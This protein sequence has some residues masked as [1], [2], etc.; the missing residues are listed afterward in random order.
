M[1]TKI[2][3]FTTTLNRAYCL[4]ELYRSLCRQT[5]KDFEWLIIN[6]GSDDN[7]DELIKGWILEK[8]LK[9][10]VYVKNETNGGIASAMNQAFDI[11]K[12]ELFFKVDSDDYLKDNAIELIL[13]Y[14]ATIEN[15][16]YFAGVAGYRCYNNNQVIG[17]GW[18]HA[19][20]YV[21]A[22][23][24]ERKRNGLEGDKAEVYYLEVLK[25]YGPFPHVNNEKYAF[26]GMLWNRIANAGLRLRW[27]KEAIY[28]TEYRDDGESINWFKVNRRNFKAYSIYVSE[29]ASYASISLYNRFVETARYY[30]I[31]HSLKLRKKEIP[32]EFKYKSWW[33]NIAYCIGYC[34]HLY[35]LLFKKSLYKNIKKEL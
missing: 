13:K 8:K 28:V 35:R 32:Q 16:D 14:E 9:K 27:F 4:P 15:K 6:D 5:V 20:D 3:I 31:A 19:R 24:F 7:T 34:L 29:Y 23:N 18:K 1:D 2:T 17:N 12:G 11:A 33:L 26:E 30:A 22:T 25:Q 21:D 10:I